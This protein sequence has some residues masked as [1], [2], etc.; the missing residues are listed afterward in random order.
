MVEWN[1]GKLQLVEV[2]SVYEGVEDSKY[3]SFI[4]PSIRASDGVVI[5]VDG[6]D[7]VKEQVR[8]VIK[9]L[10]DADIFLNK[11]KPPVKIERQ[12]SG[13]IKFVGESFFIGEREDFL[14]VL[15]LFNI[16]NATVTAFGPVTPSDLYRALDSGS[17]F[18]PAAVLINFVEGDNSGKVLYF[19]GSQTVEDL[20][21]AFNLIRVYTKP[22]RGEVSKEAIVVRK[23]TSAGEVAEK[24][25]RGKEIRQ[26]KL[27]RNGQQ[28]LIGRQ[29][30]LEDGDIIE[31]R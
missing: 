29:E 8:F 31:V 26:I 14:D 1:G 27:Y 28:K 16:H 22:P 30:V 23:G 10:E 3:A 12:P 4:F 19:R 13:G 11:K 17:V 2:P 18:L 9:L 5:V 24:I 25:M 21:R 20:F 6:R 7:N 15:S